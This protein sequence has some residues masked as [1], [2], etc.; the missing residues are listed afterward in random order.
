MT[1]GTSSITSRTI[2][3]GYIGIQYMLHETTHNAV[4][5]GEMDGRTLSTYLSAGKPVH[6]EIY[7]VSAS[8]STATLVA[9]TEASVQPQ[10][11]STVAVDPSVVGG[12]TGSSASALVS[13]WSSFSNLWAR[14]AT[15]SVAASYGQVADRCPSSST[16]AY[17]AIQADLGVLSDE[18]PSISLQRYNTTDQLQLL[19]AASLHEDTYTDFVPNATLVA[20]VG[21]VVCTILLVCLYTLPFKRSWNSSNHSVTFRIA[22]W[23]ATIVS[24]A[25]FCVVWLICLQSSHSS[26]VGDLCT[27]LSSAMDTQLNAA[28]TDSLKL[29]K[30]ATNIWLLTGAPTSDL[31]VITRWQASLMQDYHSSSKLTSLRFGTVQGFEQSSNGTMDGAVAGV[32][33]LTQVFLGSGMPTCPHCDP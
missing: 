12:L 19:I 5:G 16:A 4:F 21:A 24:A 27:Q 17:I 32:R 23:L 31:S 33:A 14:S 26:A 1:N 3:S 13:R 11:Q 25:T 6:G 7:V 20:I 10:L 29:V 8:G 30:Q 18:S 22:L 28:L 2:S 9:A 15:V